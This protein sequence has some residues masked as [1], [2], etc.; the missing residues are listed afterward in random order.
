MTGHLN[1]RA[2]EAF[3]RQFLPLAMKDVSLHKEGI[4][5][6]GFYICKTNIPAASKN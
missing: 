2:S 3:D 5:G 6:K 4:L 1:S